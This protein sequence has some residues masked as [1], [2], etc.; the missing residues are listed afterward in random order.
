MNGDQ[1]TNLA[2]SLLAMIVSMTG[3]TSG[4][5]TI[6]AADAT[7]ENDTMDT[8]MVAAGTLQSIMVGGNRKGK[9]GKKGSY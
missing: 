3:K 7:E 8:S 2:D 4:Q 9:R 1:K 6:S 5:A